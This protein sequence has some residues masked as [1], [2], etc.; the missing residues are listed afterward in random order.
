MAKDQPFRREAT[1]TPI[2]KRSCLRSV[3]ILGAMA[4]LAIAPKDINIRF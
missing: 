4:R 2:S 3:K 1:Y